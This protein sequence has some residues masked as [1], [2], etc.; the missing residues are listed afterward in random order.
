MVRGICNEGLPSRSSVLI[1]CRTTSTSLACNPPH[2]L[3]PRDDRKVGEGGKWERGGLRHPAMSLAP[4]SDWCP[5]G[6]PAAGA[7]FSSIPHATALPLSIFISA[8]LL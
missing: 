2:S 7:V 8:R 1:S 3:S 5:L 6:P 4:K